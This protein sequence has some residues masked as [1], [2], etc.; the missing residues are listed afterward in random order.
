MVKQDI[1]LGLFGTGRKSG[2]YYE[3]WCL[4]LSRGTGPLTVGLHRLMREAGLS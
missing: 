4:L 1:N 2:G 3:T